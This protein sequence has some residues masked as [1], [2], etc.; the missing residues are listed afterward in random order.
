MPVARVLAFHDVPANLSSD[1]HA[2]IEVL[3]KLSNIVSL[4]DIFA[5]KL[6]C[7]KVNIAITFDDGYR[8]WI[9]T[10]SPVLREL[11]VTATFFVSSGFV[12]LQNCDVT[13][14]LRNNLKTSQQTTGSINAEELR[15][16]ADNGFTIG[17]H[18]GNHANLSALS[19]INVVRNEILS[20]KEVLE[21]T[22]GTKIEYFA[23]PFGYHHNAHIDLAKVLRESGYRGAVT[24][25]PGLISAITNK[26]CVN[27]DLVRASMLMPVFKARFLG[28]HDGVKF[29]RK[30]IGL[31]GLVSL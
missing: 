18:T 29:L 25:V 17:G 4:N 22:T 24:L 30:I 10:V 23:Y 19:D 9:D 8:S 3:K 12:G 1:F 28:N 2:K 6:S 21:R 27:R 5:G 14:F 31:P 16:L 11:G 13:D 26:Y 20:D 7:Q 15:K